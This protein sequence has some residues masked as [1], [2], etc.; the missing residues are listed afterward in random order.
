MGNDTDTGEYDSVLVPFLGLMEEELENSTS[1]RDPGRWPKIDRKEAVLGVYRKV[2]DLDRAVSDD[3]RFG[4]KAG[5]ARVANA[6]MKVVSACV[7]KGVLEA[8]SP[9]RRLLGMRRSEIADLRFSF[10]TRNSAYEAG[11]F[12]ERARLAVADM[13]SAKGQVA[14]ADALDYIVAMRAENASLRQ[15]LDGVYWGWQGVPE[16]DNLHSLTCPIYINPE[17]MRKALAEAYVAGKNHATPFLPI[18]GAIDSG[19]D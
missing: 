14:L 9:G 10:M 12:V 6:A 4:I 13:D 18:S 5:A 19:E 17:A 11:A 7:E 3:N 15:A 2:A 8:E 1:D 16:E